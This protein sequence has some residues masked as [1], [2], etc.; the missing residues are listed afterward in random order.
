VEAE[1][2]DLN[3]FMRAGGGDELVMD[4]DDIEF[5]LIS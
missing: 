5:S 4:D 3:G 1:C 2:A